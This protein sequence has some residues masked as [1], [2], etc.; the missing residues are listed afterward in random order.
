MKNIVLFIKKVSNPIIQRI[1]FRL[2]SVNVVTFI[3]FNKYNE[4]EFRGVPLEEI[5]EYKKTTREEAMNYRDNFLKI[6]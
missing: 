4:C 5:K 6:F 1:T 3:G 2:G